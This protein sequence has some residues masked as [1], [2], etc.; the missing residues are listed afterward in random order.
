MQQ[1]PVVATGA[2]GADHDGERRP[3]RDAQL[4]G[5]IEHAEEVVDVGEVHADQV[6]DVAVGVLRFFHDLD[7]NLHAQRWV[8]PRVRAPTTYEHA[9]FSFEGLVFDF[10][11]RCASAAA[12]TKN[13]LAIERNEASVYGGR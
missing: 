2:E 12:V 8:E 11:M 4:L 7:G 6:L 9:A 10:S 3:R 13:R 1:A 5:G